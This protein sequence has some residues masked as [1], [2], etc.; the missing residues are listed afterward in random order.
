MYVVDASAW[1]L[2]GK[3]RTNMLNHACVHQLQ[4]GACAPGCF[5]LRV[6]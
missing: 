4:A 6:S 3:V 5:C 2:D 1:F